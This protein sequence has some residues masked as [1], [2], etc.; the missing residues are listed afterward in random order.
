MDKSARSHELFRGDLECY[1]GNQ[2]DA[3]FC[4]NEESDSDSD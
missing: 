3:D 2:G 1:Y 4:V